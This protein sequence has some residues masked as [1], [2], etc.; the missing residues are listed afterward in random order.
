MVAD[1]FKSMT[2]ASTGAETNAVVDLEGV[3]FI[4]STGL[5]TLVQ[6][7]KRCREEQGDLYL[8][9]LRQPIR[10]IFELTRLDKAFKIYG[11]LQEAAQAFG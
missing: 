5:A 6:G 7:M 11:N 10:I 3:S 2:A 4:D 8:V 9:G 1:W